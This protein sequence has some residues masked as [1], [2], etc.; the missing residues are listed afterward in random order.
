[1][2]ELLTALVVG[3]IGSA[4]VAIW[5]ERRST[6]QRDIHALLKECRETEGWDEKSESKLS[7]WMLDVPE[8]DIHNCSLRK[9]YQIRG[10]LRE[11]LHVH[12]WGWDPVPPPG[13]IE[14][15][16]RS[17]LIW[18]EARR[19]NK[20]HN[21]RKCRAAKHGGKKKVPS[22]YVTAERK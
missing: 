17:I 1:M 15:F 3:I 20:V 21:P 12:L 9:L 5:F 16:V 6:Y 2:F 4:V 22:T 10:S 11:Y 19:Q 13:R 7:Q 18:M 8:S 14:L